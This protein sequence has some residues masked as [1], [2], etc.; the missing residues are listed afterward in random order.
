MRQCHRSVVHGW[1]CLELFVPSPAPACWDPG[2]LW[3]NHPPRTHACN[4]LLPLL[5]LRALWRLL[6]RKPTLSPSL[7]GATGDWKGET[8]QHGLLLSKT[9][10]QR[11]TV[12]VLPSVTSTTARTKKWKKK[13]G[14]QN[15]R[16]TLVQ[17]KITLFW[18]EEGWW[19]RANA[20]VS[21]NRS[22]AT[23]R[24][25]AREPLRGP[26]GARGPGPAPDS[27]SR[28][29]R[30]GGGAQPHPQSPAK[31][32]LSPPRSRLGAAIL[33]SPCLPSL[34]LPPGGRRAPRRHFEARLAPPLSPEG[35]A[36]RG[37]QLLPCPAYSPFL[38][39]FIYCLIFF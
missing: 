9:W 29:A 15:N 7:L 36:G 24:G 34:P 30:A 17:Q 6:G 3:P 39:K 23:G 35:R 38:F 12:V 1:C 27:P 28:R 2:L 4:T 18:G 26:P 13:S 5:C 32:R 8:Q 31:S 16:A 19:N 14:E 21:P 11:L 10:G 22:E 20:T 33:S 25:A 37:W